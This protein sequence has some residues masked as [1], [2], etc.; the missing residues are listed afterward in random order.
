MKDFSMSM[1][2]SREDLYRDKA[3]HLELLFKVLCDCR[4]TRS[5]LSG[6]LNVN[7]TDDPEAFFEELTDVLEGINCYM[8]SLNLRNGA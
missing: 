5:A 7:D 2:T 8:K 3:A 6:I 1:Y 4:D